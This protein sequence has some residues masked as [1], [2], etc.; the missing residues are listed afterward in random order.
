MIRIK[1]KIS[2]LK[3]ERLISITGMKNALAYHLEVSVSSRD[4]DSKSRDVEKKGKIEELIIQVPDGETVES[5][6]PLFPNAAI[7]EAEA[8]E[9]F[10]MKFD[11]NPMS[12]MRLFQ[13]ERESGKAACYP[14]L[15]PLDKERK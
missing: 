6:I 13:A 10:G 5:L 4:R 3:A 14:M 9:L 15:D 12:G 8:T 2:K 7:F 1:E 11:G